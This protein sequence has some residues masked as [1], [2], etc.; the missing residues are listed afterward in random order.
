MAKKTFYVF[1]NT[2]ENGLCYD[3]ESIYDRLKDFMCDAV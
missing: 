1:G 2:G 3:D